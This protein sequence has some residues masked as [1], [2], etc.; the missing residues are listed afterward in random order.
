[1]NLV[2]LKMSKLNDFIKIVISKQKSI[3]EKSILL[4]IKPYTEFNSIPFHEAMNVSLIDDNQLILGHTFLHKCYGDS[5]PKIPKTATEQIH[6]RFSE[7]MLK[8]GMNHYNFDN[9]DENERLLG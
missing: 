3:R 9:L 7:E 2:E 5:K 1:M 4:N 8:R 6:L